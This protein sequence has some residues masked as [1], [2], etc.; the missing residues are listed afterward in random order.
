MYQLSDAYVKW[1]TDDKLAVQGVDYSVEWNDPVNPSYQ[2]I[3]VTPFQTLLDKIGTGLNRVK[4]G[5][6]EPFLTDF[7]TDDAFV[8]EKIVY[9]FDR[10]W[11]GLQQVDEDVANFVG[12]PGPQGIPGPEGPQGDEGPIGPAGA[13]GV[14]GVDGVDGADGAT[15]PQGPIGN[16]GP[17]GATG[18]TGATGP[19]GADSTVPGPQGPQGLSGLATISDTAPV[20]PAHRDLWWESDTG[21]LFMYYNDGTSSQWVEVVGGGGPISDPLKANLSGAVFTGDITIQ[22]PDADLFVIDT[23][24]GAITKHTQANSGAYDV[25]VDVADVIA[26]SSHRIDIDGQINHLLAKTGAQLFRDGVAPVGGAKGNGTFNIPHGYYVDGVNIAAGFLHGLTISNNASDVTNDIDVAIGSAADSTAVGIMGLISAITKR[27]DA[28]WTVGHN[29]GGRMSAAAIADT[30]YHVFLIKRLDTGVV[31][32]GL[33]VSPTA[34]TLP[35]NYTLFRRIGSIMRIAGVIK[36]FKQFGDMFKLQG[37][38]ATTDWTAAA[39]VA[40]ANV[41]V[42]IPTGIV[43]SPSFRVTCTGAGAGFVSMASGDGHDV[44]LVVCQSNTGDSARSVVAPDV[45]YSNTSAQVRLQYD[46]ASGVCSGTVVTIGY[47]DT[48]GKNGP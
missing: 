38:T 34:P 39:S 4:I 45:F 13:D 27:L 3:I 1:G 32:V 23:T 26:G 48:R 9:E 10:V 25:I 8:R 11:L 43:V 5:R 41:A 42:T 35:A 14:D 16:T 31:D 6:D 21:K 7:D 18:A 40:I 29:G 46:L 2:S 28:A 15:G 44:V 19:T 12:P 17:T 24:S 30:T 36:P 20:S 33:D 22:S 47:K 37:P